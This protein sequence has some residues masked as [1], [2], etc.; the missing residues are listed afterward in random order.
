MWS[1]TVYQK[2]GDHFVYN[3]V[4]PYGQ[5]TVLGFLQFG[6]RQICIHLGGD[7]AGRV[8]NILNQVA[9]QV[10]YRIPTFF[11]AWLEAIWFGSLI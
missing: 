11:E 7:G 9:K 2:F 10:A 1:K 5:I 8:Y 3:I 6:M 4:E